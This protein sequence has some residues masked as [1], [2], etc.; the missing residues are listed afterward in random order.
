MITSL[1]MAAYY[2][3]AQGTFDLG[4]MDVNDEST[5]EGEIWDF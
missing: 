3:V 1:S 4:S 5:Q 2:E